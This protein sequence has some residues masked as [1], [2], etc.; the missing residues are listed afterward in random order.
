M[1]ERTGRRGGFEAFV[2]EIAEITP[3]EFSRLE[4]GE[5]RLPR[6]WSL[7]GANDVPRPR[8]A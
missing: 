7:D 8:A 2:T 1:R 4:R 6:G 3:D 5:L